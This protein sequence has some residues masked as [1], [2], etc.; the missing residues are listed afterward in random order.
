MQMRK[1]NE[2]SGHPLPRWREG[3]EIEEKWNI[4][5]T[6]WLLNKVHLISC[7]HGNEQKV[8]SVKNLIAENT[9]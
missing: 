7:S 1:E 8:A 9:D 5:Y 3:E 6:H 4:L 2:K